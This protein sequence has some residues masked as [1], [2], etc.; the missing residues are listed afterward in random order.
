MNI[1]EAL[2]MSANLI[3]NIV[4]GN[5]PVT[6][7]IGYFNN[8]SECWRYFPDAD[9]S[10]VKWLIENQGLGD[11]IKMAAAVG[12][13]GMQRLETINASVL[14]VTSEPHILIDH[15][16]RLEA[17]WTRQQGLATLRRF[18]LRLNDPQ[19]DVQAGKI[20]AECSQS[21]MQVAQG[22]PRDVL[23]P[24]DL[25]HAAMQTL[26]QR[27]FDHSMAVSLPVKLRPGELCVVGGLA[28]GG[29]TALA[30]QL[31]FEIA[32]KGQRVFF[33]ETEMN[34]GNMLLR[35][36]YRQNRLPNGTFDAYRAALGGSETLAQKRA[37]MQHDG[38]YQ[39]LARTLERLSQLPIVYRCNKIGETADQIRT[40]ARRAEQDGGPLSLI[41][42]DHIKHMGTREKAEEANRVKQAYQEVLKLKEAFPSACIIVLQHLNTNIFRRVGAA[43][44]PGQGDLEYGGAGAFDVGYII[45][46]PIQHAAQ[47]NIDLSSLKQKAEEYEEL[48]RKGFLFTVKDRNGPGE[49]AVPLRFFGE[50]YHWE[51]K[52]WK[53]GDH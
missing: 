48:R 51:V 43:L 52:D 16:A 34:V 15:A 26:D 1:A 23:E 5:L 32:Q 19:E 41:V 22:L 37:A 4:T 33:V 11:M 7:L 44:A 29:K 14:A 39:A 28:G 27:I 45:M 47:L 30:S 36:A 31:A 35:E 46:R 8:S 21:L 49:G 12:D 10:L 20:L 9:Q 3:M 42:I 38:R 2:A 18:A 6:D 24:A 40:A 25:L 17:D 13:E 50:Y 53:H